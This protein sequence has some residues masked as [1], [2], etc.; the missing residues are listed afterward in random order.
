MEFKANLLETDKQDY[1]NQHLK[2]DV[3]NLSLKKSPFKDLAMRDLIQQID[4]KKRSEKKLP[5]WFACNQIYYPPKI[6]IEQSSSEKTAR[7]KAD[8]VEGNL[9]IDVTG[10]F[11]VDDFYFSQK[12]KKLIHCELNASLSAIAMHNLTALGIKNIEFFF[13]DGN[14]YINNEAFIDCIYIDP[15]RRTEKGRVFFLSDC[16]P[17]VVRNLD[18]YLLK[19]KR[20][21]IKV[22]PMLDIQSTLAELKQVSE[23]HILSVQNECKE[24][25]Y[26]ID[27]DFNGEPKI[28]C[29]LLNKTH[30]EIL[31]FNITEEKSL[32]NQVGAIEKYLYESDASLLKAGMFKSIAKKYDLIK[33][34]ANT[35]LYTS[36]QLISGFP[37]RTMEVIAI[38]DYQQFSTKKQKLKANVVTRNFNLKPEE[39]RKKLKISDGGETYL[40]FT[41]NF[42]DQKVVIETRRLFL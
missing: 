3:V 21:I 42:K 8:L 2:T 7:Y 16:E 30:N 39:I 12:V 22:S 14:Q 15:S 20:I 19:A 37:G 28:I 18:L 31:T 41:T 38:M 33:L 35:H 17:D 5:T 11:G 29:A 34:H 32:P 36:K 27:R 24:I 26:I 4:S 25:I 9:L 23:V 40:Y 1:I 13:G 10:G 6:N